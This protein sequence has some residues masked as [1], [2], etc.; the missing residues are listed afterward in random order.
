MTTLND[1]TDAM[2]WAEEFCRIFNR[3]TIYDV[4][5]EGNVISPGTMVGW[6]A[7]AMEVGR[8]EGAQKFCPH[9]MNN[10]TELAD[11]LTMC[12]RCGKVWSESA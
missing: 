5:Q 10:R 4:E 1:T 3:Q 7:N 6:F 8:R 12:Q 11:A 9:N 2:L